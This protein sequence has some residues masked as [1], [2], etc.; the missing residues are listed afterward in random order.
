M[1]LS[2]ATLLFAA[3]AA[4]AACDPLSGTCPS[5]PALEG[6]V[7]VDLSLPNPYFEGTDGTEINYPSNGTALQLTLGSAKTKSILSTKYIMFGRV[8]A[9][10]KAAS[11]PGVDTFFLIKS[12][13]FDQMSFRIVGGNNSYVQT[14]WTSLGNGASV[15]NSM[16]HKMLS[17][18]SDLFHTY[19]LEY[20]PDR[21]T[22][23]I[24]GLVV[25]NVLAKDV[26]RLPQTPM[27]VVCGI[28]KADEPFIPQ[29]R[30][31][32]FK[33]AVSD[34]TSLKSI[35]LNNFSTGSLY[36]YVGG[37]TSWNSIKATGG[38]V[39]TFNPPAGWAGQGASGNN[40]AGSFSMVPTPTSSVVLVTSTTT[41]S[42]TTTKTTTNTISVSVSTATRITSTS[43]SGGDAPSISGSWSLG[44]FVLAIFATLSYIV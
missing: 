31:F 13:V 42:T 7:T 8:D 6:S 17:S 25:R 28:Y 5:N 37:S 29:K 2:F 14:N 16:D 43:R 10:L 38:T 35:G 9:T 39:S 36:S 40:P 27:A 1:K 44:S 12:D 24:D 3:T 22:F 20:T 41:D 11:D 30:S 15:D 21:I 18:N 4:G 19:S 23:Y 33:R 26:T 34:A 32:S